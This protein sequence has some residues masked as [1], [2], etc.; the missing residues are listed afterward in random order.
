MANF[1]SPFEKWGRRRC[2]FRPSWHYCVPCKS[3]RFSF[4]LFFSV[5]DSFESL[6]WSILS[7][8]FIIIQRF[9]GKKFFYHELNLQAGLVLITTD[10]LPWHS[11]S[12]RTSAVFSL[13]KLSQLWS[14]QQS[15]SGCFYYLAN[16]QFRFTLLVSKISK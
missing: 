11:T 6:T 5:F 10:K 15:N 9:S 4:V 8:V 3:P 12:V 7:W 2:R 14:F 13:L 16:K 1:V